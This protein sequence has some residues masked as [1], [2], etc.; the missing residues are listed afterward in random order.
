MKYNFQNPGILQPLLG[1]VNIY[2]V[3]LG[4]F[5]HPYTPN[6]S[7]MAIIHRAHSVSLKLIH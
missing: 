1:V 7:S 5:T 3:H 2:L 4:T 6:T